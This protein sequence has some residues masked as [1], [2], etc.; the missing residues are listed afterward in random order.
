MISERGIDPNPDKIKSLLDMKPPNSYKDIQRLTRCLAA[1]SRFTSESGERNFPFFKN[2]RK[3]Y[4]TNIGTMSA[5]K[6]SK[7]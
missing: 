4:P 5:I 7:T 1:L 6:L 3:A 2:L